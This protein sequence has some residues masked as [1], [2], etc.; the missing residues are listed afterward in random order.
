MD[1]GKFKE[2]ITFE[3]LTTTTDAEGSTVETW[4]TLFSRW[5]DIQINNARETFRNNQ[6]FQTREGFALVRRDGETRTLNANDRFI[7]DGEPWEIL[8]VVNMNNSDEVLELG[9][10]RYGQ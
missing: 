2:R 6:S 9:I 1:A 10:R 5:A 8:G 3:R 7:Y 4:T